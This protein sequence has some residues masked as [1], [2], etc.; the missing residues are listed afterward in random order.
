MVMTQ[1]EFLRK[2][3]KSYIGHP[4]EIVNGELIVNTTIG[5]V[6]EELPVKGPL[7]NSIKF[8]SN[9]HVIIQETAT[10]YDLTFDNHGLAEINLIEC[11]SKI[12]FT[13]RCTNVY[14][15]KLE[16][17]KEG[18]H[19]VFENVGRV[20]IPKLE[21]LTHSMEF[22]NQGHAELDS[23]VNIPDG[24]AFRSKTSYLDLNSYK[25]EMD[26]GVS[27]TSSVYFYKG[28]TY[29]WD[30]NIEGIKPYKILTSL[31]K[32]NK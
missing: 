10:S 28:N 3:D 5:I 12:T 29:D 25:P 13:E 22:K 18:A 16:F 21:Y 7:F 8:I 9:Q 1:E 4:Y 17:I 26:T 15:K 6:W 31:L 2:L 14:L 27:F 11:K 30:C 24:F 20:S 19:L 32:K 23:V